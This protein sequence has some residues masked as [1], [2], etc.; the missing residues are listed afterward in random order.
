MATEK[1]MDIIQDP[2]LRFLRSMPTYYIDTFAGYLYVFRKTTHSR[3]VTILT[4]E[5]VGLEYAQKVL[6]RKAKLHFSLRST[7]RGNI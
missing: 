7:D 3:P 5:R 6:T 1:D 4:G 2:R